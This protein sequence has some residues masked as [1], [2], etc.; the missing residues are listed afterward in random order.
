[1]AQ[2]FVLATGGIENARLL[3]AS[4]RQQPVGLGNG[5][6][7]VG[8]FFMDHPRLM[9][10]N[11]RFAKAWARNKLYDIKYHYQNNAV[12]AHGTRIAAQFA[13]APE[14]LRQ[15]RLL[16]ARVWFSSIFH[17]EGSEGAKALYRCKQ[18]LL[19]KDQPGWSMTRDAATMALH[20]VDTFA[21][22][23]TRL[24]QPRS[25]IN[26][27]RFQA[28]AE[29]APDPDSR[30]TLSSSRYDVLGMPRV[31]VHWR[32]SDQVKR[33]FD[34][35]LAML[36][37]EL[38]HG[39]VA[40]VDLDSP[41]EGGDWPSAFEQEGTWHHMGTT[42]MHDS[43]KCGVVDRNC[44]VHGMTNLYVAGSSVF[45]TAGAN[46]P[47]ITIAALALRLSEHIAGEL[48]APAAGRSGAADKTA[49]HAPLESQFTH[50]TQQR[51]L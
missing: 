36:T 25:L 27:V 48:N 28:I 32:L 34:R 42:R 7:L 46:F 9:S 3:L 29:P 15:E 8:R 45:P 26:G 21:Y 33:T 6:D 31:Q 2:R 39:G 38:R 24:F 14:I 19:K 11:I 41:I 49:A 37:D 13:L 44:Q 5:N 43:P 50:V 23:F 4:N 47:T 30:V 40:D 20:P 51:L 12:A 22:G 16:N 35:T 1:A 18:A 10:G 17:G